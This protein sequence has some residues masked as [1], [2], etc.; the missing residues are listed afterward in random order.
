MRTALIALGLIVAG[1]VLAVVIALLKFSDEERN[2]N[3]WR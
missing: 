2:N 3:D 1:L